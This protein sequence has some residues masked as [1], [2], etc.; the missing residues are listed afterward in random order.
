MEQIPNFE[1]TLHLNLHRRW[2]DMILK[3]VKKEEYRE[4]SAYWVKRLA[5]KNFS[6]IT[7]SNG[8]A[9]NR[10]QFVIEWCCLQTSMGLLEWG[11]PA[12]KQVYILRLGKILWKN[13]YC[14]E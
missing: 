9:K 8:Y 2:F 13:K 7:F 12:D 3:G 11:A 4:I 10:R 14:N 6:T 1:N 5:S